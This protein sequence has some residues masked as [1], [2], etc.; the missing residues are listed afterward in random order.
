MDE[1]GHL[2]GSHTY[3]HIQLCRNNREEFKQA[4]S[5]Q[6]D[7]GGYFG[8]FICRLGIASYIRFCYSGIDRKYIKCK[9]GNPER[10]G[11]GSRTELGKGGCLQGGETDDTILTAVHGRSLL[12][13]GGGGCHPAILR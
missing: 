12:E 6:R 7:T 5:G 13:T 8:A 3:S 1:E 4:D 9:M 2:I 11:A 10:T